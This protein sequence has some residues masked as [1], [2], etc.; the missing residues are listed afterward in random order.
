MADDPQA[1]GDADAA[2]DPSGDRLRQ[3]R[4]AI[5]AFT[6][7]AVRGATDVISP[8]VIEQA[9]ALP[10]VEPIHLP[11][12][13]PGAVSVSEIDNH[14]LVYDGRQ[15]HPTADGIGGPPAP[16]ADLPASPQPLD[17]AYQQHAAERESAALDQEVAALKAQA[18]AQ[19][20][21]PTMGGAESP[22][23]HAIASDIGQGIGIEG[24]RS[25]VLGAKSAVNENAAGLEQQ[26]QDVQHYL[27]AAGNAALSVLNPTTTAQEALTALGI[28]PR[29][30]VTDEEQPKTVTG[31]LI[32]NVSQFLTGMVGGGKALEG[33]KAATAA[34]GVAKSLATG[35]IADFSAFTR[36]A[37]PTCS[38]PMRLSRSDRSLTS[39]PRTRTTRSSS[40]APRPP[41]RAWALARCRTG[42]STASRRC[43][44]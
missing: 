24:M 20:A 25:A 27:G 31:G 33:W 44:P 22:Q 21:S 23:F 8:G 9:K 17:A 10:G 12:I 2:D 3:V 1:A 32:K 6:P 30:P 19:T 18:Q 7:S 29:L 40:R 36:R 11:N 15:P 38:H 43:G 42:C 41:S 39:W 37:C 28:H 16:V 34:G 26:Q 5:G 4:D 35:A 13:A 14:P